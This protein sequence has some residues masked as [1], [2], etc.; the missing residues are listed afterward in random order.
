MSTFVFRMTLSKVP[1]RLPERMY[2]A[3]LPMAT[4]RVP[5]WIRPVLNDSEPLLSFRVSVLPTLLSVP[6]MKV[7]PPVLTRPFR[8]AVPKVP[9]RLSVLPVAVCS[10]PVLVQLV[11]LMRTSPPP[12]ASTVPWLSKLVPATMSVWLAVA[13]L[14]VIVPLLMRL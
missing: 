3:L 9:S 8:A 10:V 11:A 5:P 6:L 4:A 14:P 7:V 13:L 2:L 1:L 12:V